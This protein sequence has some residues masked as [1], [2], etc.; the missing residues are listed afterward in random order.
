M[1][2]QNGCKYC[3]RKHSCKFVGCEKVEYIKA[4]AHVIYA[5]QEEEK[6]WK[7]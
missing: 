6:Y 4:T 3:D 7:I 5:K 1:N 2:G